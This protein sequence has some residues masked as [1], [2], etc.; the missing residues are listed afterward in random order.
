MWEWVLQGIFGFFL[1]ID[2]LLAN[3]I[4]YAYQV[5][6]FLANTNILPI[7]EFDA[8]I[9]RIYVIIAVIMLFVVTYSLLKALVN[10]DDLSKGDTSTAKIASNIVISIIIIAVV[11]TIFDFGHRIQS[12]ILS[13]NIIGRIILGN[14]YVGVDSPSITQQG[15]EVSASIFRTF[16]RAAPGFNENEIES[17]GNW[18]FN[19]TLSLAE[20]WTITSVE[21]DFSVLRIFAGNLVGDDRD[22]EYD[23]LISTIALAFVA[24]VFI[25]FCFDLGIRVVKLAFLQLIAPIP[26]LSRIMPGQKKI[27]DQWIKKSVATY[28]EVFIRLIIIFFGVYLI[29]LVN[30]YFLTLPQT[31]ESVSFG[32]AGI[33]QVLIIMGVV[34]FMRQAPKLIGDMFGLD[35]GNI[36][37]GIGEKL[38]AGGGGVLAGAAAGAIGG[39]GLG[40]KITGAFGGG[41]RGRNAKTMSEAM[42]NQ[43]SRNAALRQAKLADSTFGGRMGARFKGAFGLPDAIDKDLHNYEEEIK[44]YD[45]QIK[46]LEETN[47][48]HQKIVRQQK[49]FSDSIDAMQERARKKIQEGKG[50]VG[51]EY[52]RK[53]SD[54]ETL[55]AEMASGNI[56]VTSADIANAQNEVNKMM[57]SSKI[58]EYITTSL[59]AT[60]GTD[61]YDIVLNQNLHSTYENVANS[62]EKTVQRDG[63]LIDDQ[64]NDAKSTITRESNTMLDTNRK[65]AAINDSKAE[66]A[67]KQAKLYPKKKTYEANKNAINKK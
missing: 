2:T 66:V 41:W 18:R 3:F 48:P 53:L 9:Q 10:P 38:V 39:Q 32:V 12:A 15:T 63:T 54:L 56:Y 29:N 31:Q 60:E 30:I 58:N 65:I 25:S 45:N 46:E 24:F 19:N 14:P 57:S 40:G 52:I 42:Q 55:K 16:F 5:F 33:S 51:Q 47:V 28:L 21:S 50:V 43:A 11:P 13:E 17:R 64:G 27:F 36:K 67:S 44:E 22:I 59:S 1:M 35:S 4:G 49:E 34:A 62:L 26:A 8:F 23:F 37:L 20:A 7:N 61:D 6:L